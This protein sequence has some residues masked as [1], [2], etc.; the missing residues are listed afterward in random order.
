MKGYYAGKKTVQLYQ[1][2]F[3]E[4]SDLRDRVASTLEYLA[5]LADT[6]D[7]R[8]LKRRLLEVRTKERKG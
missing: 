6:E 1:G 4:I 3:D 7:T 2:V 5:T 8:E